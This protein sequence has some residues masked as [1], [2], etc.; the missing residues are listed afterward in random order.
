MVQTTQPYPN[1][2][3]SG[4]VV[5]PIL[6]Q[7]DLWA[8]DA[9]RVSSQELCG[10]AD[11]AQ[12]TVYGR[13][14]DGRIVQW[15][16]LALGVGTAY[17]SGAITFSGAGTAADTVTIG[18]RVIT[19][20]ASGAVG[21]QINIGGSA[22]ATAQNLKN[23]INGDATFPVDASGAAAV[24]TLTAK[25]AGTGGNAIT[26]TEAG[27][28]TSFGAATLAGGTTDATNP[29]PES[30]AIGVTAQPLQANE[31]GPV[32]VGGIFNPEALIWPATIN[33]L[34][35]RKAAFDGTTLGVRKL[36]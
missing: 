11:L 28:G 8:G 29:A 9:P 15:N 18:G 10:S 13:A 14:A 36:L 17:A 21:D 12:H 22:T 30:K 6:T 24:I 3:A 35:E 16:P 31:M 2:L 27:T 5:Q 34:A 4:V 33:T 7:Q 32:W 1:M 25:I 23:L 19:M 20:V 26:T